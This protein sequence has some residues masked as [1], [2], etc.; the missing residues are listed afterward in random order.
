MNGWTANDA[1]N[2]A[3][4]VPIGSNNSTTVTAPMML[5]GNGYTISNL[6]SKT[7][8]IAVYSAT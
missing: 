4:W 2:N 7:P 6:L 3:G 1:R 5:Q 8:L